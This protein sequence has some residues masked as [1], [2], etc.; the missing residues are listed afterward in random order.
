VSKNYDR[1]TKE[2]PIGEQ[3][4]PFLS[5]SRS[6]PNTPRGAIETTPEEEELSKE[7]Q[8]A[9]LKEKLEFTEKQLKDK[10]LQLDHY[11]QLV[12]T[13]KDVLAEVSG[14]RPAPG[15]APLAP[16]GRAQM[17][18]PGFETKAKYQIKGRKVRSFHNDYYALPL[19]IEE[20][21]PFPMK[22][23]ETEKPASWR[24]PLSSDEPSETSP[25]KKSSKIPKSAS[26]SAISSISEDEPRESNGSGNTSGRSSLRSSGGG[27]KFSDGNQQKSKV[28]SL[29][30]SQSMT[31]VYTVLEENRLD[32]K[33]PD[34]DQMVGQIYALSKYQQGCRFLQKKL[35]E[36]NPDNTKIILN[37][38]FDHLVE[39]MTDPFGNYL[40]SKLM[41]HCDVQQREKV[42]EKILPDIM[43]TAF[44]MY[45]TQSL[46]KMIPCLSESQTNSIIKTLKENAIMLIKHNK[47]NYLIQYFLDNLPPNQSQ[48]IYDSVTNSI[49]EVSRDR[50]GCVIVKRCVDHAGLEQKNRLAEEVTKHALVLVQD[51]FGNYVVQHI[52]EKYTGEDQADKLIRQ[53]L[54]SVTELCTQKFSSNV[55][56]KCLQIASDETRGDILKEITETDMLPQL[57]NDRFAN[58]VVQT[59]LDVANPEQRQNLVK[60]ILPHLG[61]HYSPYTKRLQKKILQV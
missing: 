14:R 19:E 11:K 52:L 31:S 25:P 36:K 32:L 28:G 23:S 8:I 15:A 49:E 18:P 26:H 60:N 39:L 59:A 48:W 24:K 6:A 1:E 47:A 3:T 50:V 13:L 51:P 38:L 61:R 27:K 54:G 58:F 33:F 35:D 17:P 53:M 55:I 45:G 37:E 34:L 21:D 9:F 29:K 12:K 44:D 5:K 20:E 40:F 22:S 56:E 42:I 57:L 4:L 2:G 16:Q 30:K 43:S 7:M 10:D 41:E 46:Q